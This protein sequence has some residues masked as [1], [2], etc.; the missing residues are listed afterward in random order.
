MLW[1]PNPGR[2]LLDTWLPLRRHLL[3]WSLQGLGRWGGPVLV[4]PSLGLAPT[5]WRGGSLSTLF[6]RSP[7]LGRCSW[8]RFLG[9]LTLADVGLLWRLR[10]ALWRLAAWLV[11][12]CTPA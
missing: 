3:G 5:G 11:S 9:W 1:R 8:S 2:L 6:R 7:L 10:G 12:L 4:P